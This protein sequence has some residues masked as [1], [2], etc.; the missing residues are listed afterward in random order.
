MYFIYVKGD[1]DTGADMFETKAD[2]EIQVNAMLQDGY[3]MDDIVVY[4]G[5]PV[6]MEYKVTIMEE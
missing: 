5:E 6:S 4:K 1:F 3:A 2:V